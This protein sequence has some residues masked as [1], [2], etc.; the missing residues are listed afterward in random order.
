MAIAL[1][2]A[3]AVNSQI[4]F[5]RTTLTIRAAPTPGTAN[6]QNAQH[7]TTNN[8]AKITMTV[9]MRPISFFADPGLYLAKPLSPSDA[10]LIP[11]PAEDPLHMIRP[12]NLLTPVDVVVID[13]QGVINQIFPSLLL[14]ELQLPITL[15]DNSAA[16][17]YLAQGSTQLLDIKPGYIVEH[18]LFTP[19]PKV[20]K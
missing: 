10:Y 2:L 13:K 1:I 6:K 12:S 20:I 18:E 8:H 3:D 4:V 9:E 14:S 16:I 15:P 19:P 7:D 11:L 17:L 5:S